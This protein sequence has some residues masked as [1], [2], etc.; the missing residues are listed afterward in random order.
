MFWS[1]L[2]AGASKK[3]L[4]ETGKELRNPGPERPKGEALAP[5]KWVPGPQP[6][7]LE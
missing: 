4:S 3:L 1:K 7:A 2:S 6:L 5:S